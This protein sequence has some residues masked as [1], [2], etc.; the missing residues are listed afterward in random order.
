[1]SPVDYFI[2]NMTEH[3]KML[4]EPG[5]L[6]AMRKNYDK[7]K[8]KT[9]GMGPQLKIRILAYERILSDRNPTITKEPGG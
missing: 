9:C 4:V 2:R 5:I 3:Q 1:M 8:C 7:L 6:E